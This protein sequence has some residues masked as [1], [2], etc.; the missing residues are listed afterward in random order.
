[1]E[2]SAGGRCCS[3]RDLPRPSFPER[4]VGYKEVV[5]ADPAGLWILLLPRARDSSGLC[6]PPGSLPDLPVLP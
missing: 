3:P 6:P 4:G 1:M 2:V 5:R